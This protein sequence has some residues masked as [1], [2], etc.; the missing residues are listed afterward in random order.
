MGSRMQIYYHAL[1]GYV[2]ARRSPF[3]TWCIVG[4]VWPDAHY[5]VSWLVVKLQHLPTFPLMFTLPWAKMI[6][7]AT[8][9]AVFWGVVALVWRGARAR[10]FLAGWLSHIIAD[11]FSHREL[12]PP[13]FWPLL[14]TPVPG[15]FSWH[16]PAAA[17][18]LAIAAAAV[19]TWLA[20]EGLLGRRV[21]VR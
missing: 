15:L 16:E 12:A 17:R 14:R 2:V 4:A 5:V 19:V 9:S 7:A 1:L 11:L 21:G 8:H 20:V 3:V 10:A 6:T 18:W 13:Y